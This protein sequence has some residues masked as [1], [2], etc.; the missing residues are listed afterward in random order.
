[1]T[2]TF[3]YDRLVSRNSGYVSA[4]IQAKIR[5]CKLLIAGCGIGSSP[6]ICAARMGFETFTLVDGDTVDN[7]NLNRQFYDFADTGRLKV[8][9]L[10]DQILRIN[11]EAKVR[12]QPVYLDNKN[13][14]ELVER[15]DVVFDTVDFL[16]LRAI[17]ALH[18]S[19][20][21]HRVHI[22][23][24][25]STGFGALVWSFPPGS[26]TT[27]TD[28]LAADFTKLSQSDAAAKPTYAEVFA[29][30]IKRLAP[31]LD[32]E[33]VEQVGRVLALMKEGKPCPASQVSVGSFAIGAM[34]VAIIHEQLLNPSNRKPEL[35]IHSFKRHQTTR[36]GMDALIS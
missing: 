29:L 10:R 25:L 3:S 12:A 11:P 1:M 14:D 19:A 35:L 33:V 9:A 8:D 5:S 4:Q 27:L 26:E 24:A 18:E 23:T 7:H 6:A 2:N 15:S 32:V 17:M 28:V 20:A 36:V 16:D 31:Y 30:F 13:I 22:L 21:K 34:A